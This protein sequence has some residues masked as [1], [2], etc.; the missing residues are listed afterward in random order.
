MLPFYHI[1]LHAIKVLFSMERVRRGFMMKKKLLGALVGAVIAFAW[2]YVSWQVLP[3]HEWSM[4]SFE[5]GGAAVT[6]A[7][8]KEALTSGLYSLPNFDKD[9]RTDKA[10]HEAWMKQAHEGPAAFVAVRLEG[11]R[12]DLIGTLVGQFITQFLVAFLGVWLLTKTI[13]VPVV[14]KA[15]FISVVVA[16]GVFLFNMGGWIWCGIPSVSVLIA[17]VDALVAWFLAG[18]GMGV[19]MKPRNA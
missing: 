3:W 10:K 1:F 7:I 8:K 12:F 15:V 4:K 5:Q 17:V 13:I 9:A 19:I 2:G 16:S 18:L 6:D 14:Q 11:M